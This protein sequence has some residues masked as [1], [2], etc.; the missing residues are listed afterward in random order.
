VEVPA[1][2]KYV[3]NRQQHSWLD[4]V[5]TISFFN[6]D[7]FA[8]SVAQAVCNTGGWVVLKQCNIMARNAGAII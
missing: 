1:V 2:C 4:G 3:T 5:F 6:E 7:V 8:V